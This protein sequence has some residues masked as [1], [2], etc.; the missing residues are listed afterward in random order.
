VTLL[1]H[2]V[3]S[4]QGA[5]PEITDRLYRYGDG[6]FE[7]LRFEA[8]Q[9]LLS[10]YH[11]DRL[12]R[13]CDVLE[14]DYP[15]AAVTDQ[16]ELATQWLAEQ[17]LTRAAGRLAVSRGDGGHGYGGQSHVPV[18]AL[19]L[20][21]LALPW[22]QA[23]ASAKLVSCEITLASQP[24]LAGIK[25]A[26]RLE[27]VLA[28]R[29]VQRRRA[30]EGVMLNPAGEV[31]CAVSGNLFV[32]C[33]GVLLTPPIVDCGVAGTLRRLVLEQL[34]E[35][36]GIVARQATLTMSDLLEA[37]E[38]LLTNALAGI[39]SVTSLDDHSFSSTALADSLREHYFAHLGWL[40]P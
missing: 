36:A 40:E 7:T 28:A 9:W 38:L 3:N 2:W 5:S 27:Q 25:H 21:E 20:Q 34:A 18:V 8:P 14:I 17:R 29:E 24:R 1:T 26:N 15:G 6:L 19:T 23:A 4:C 11:L 13:G 31:V 16:L 12:K 33:D 35:R 32:A 10:D 22:G 30:D 37:D 39:R